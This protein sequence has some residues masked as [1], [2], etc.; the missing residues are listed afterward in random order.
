MKVTPFVLIVTGLAIGQEP[1]AKVEFEVASIKPAEPLSEANAANV[2]MF[3]DAASVR[4]IGAPLG[5]L[6]GTAYRV[7]APRVLGPE[8]LPY[9]RFD[10]F[11]KIPAGVGKDQV[12]EMLQA[13]LRERF[14]LKAHYE[15][16]AKRGYILTVKDPDLL[17][18]SRIKD[19]DV[20]VKPETRGL[21]LAA[22]P[23]KGKQ[24][25]F[26]DFSLDKFAKGL[27][28][29]VGAPVMN[30][31]KAEGSYDLLVQSSVQ[32]LDDSPGYTM[33]LSDVRSSLAAQGME[34]RVS[35]FQLNYLIVDHINKVPTEN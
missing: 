10:V 19:S 31:T 30:E 27:E 32:S 25:T 9:V 35:S 6:I 16:R 13:L 11:A 28:G 4:I 5:I 15:S 22:A 17:Q 12:P 24:A 21:A 3:V 2:G 7:G 20:N 18:K 33:G 29:I 8:F 23:G 26:K 34:L 14:D 1:P